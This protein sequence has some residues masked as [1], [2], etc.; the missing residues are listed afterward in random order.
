MRN[1]RMK[2]S[3][4]LQQHKCWLEGA[5]H[6]ASEGQKPHLGT[7]DKLRGD[8]I[9]KKPPPTPPRKGSR[10]LSWWPRRGCCLPALFTGYLVFSVS[11][12]TAARSSINGPASHRCE[13]FHGTSVMRYSSSFTVLIWVCFAFSSKHGFLALKLTTRSWRKDTGFPVSSENTWGLSGQLP[14]GQAAE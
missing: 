13:E 12:L 4:F 5:W 7:V 8:Q 3:K 2:T 6:N 11:S 9:S 10:E 1:F 14:W